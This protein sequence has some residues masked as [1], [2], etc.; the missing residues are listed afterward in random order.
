[1]YVY[2]ISSQA[3]FFGPENYQQ[4]NLFTS[5]FYD[6][7]N[8]QKYCDHFLHTEKVHDKIVLIIDPPFGGMTD[9]IANGMRLLWA[10]IGTGTKLYINQKFC[11]AYL[12]LAYT[13]KYFLQ[14]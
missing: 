11:C 14:K 3:Q 12:I 2:V 10:M 8:G 9:V 1:M 6:I 4:Y 7:S 13:R 5:F